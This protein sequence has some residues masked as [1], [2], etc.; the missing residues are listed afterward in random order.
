MAENINGAVVEYFD[1]VD[2]TNTVAARRIAEGC[3]EWHTVIAKSQTAGSG[4]LLRSFFSP[5][6]TGLYMSCV[7]YPNAEDIG[8]ITGMAAVA[9]SEAME[10]L[11]KSPRIKWV[12]D[13]FIDGRKVCGILAKGICREKGMA[14]ILGIGVNVFA[15][16]GGFPEDIRETA[17]YLFDTYDSEKYNNLTSLILSSLQK[18]YADIANGDSPEQYRK[19]CITTGREVKVIPSGNEGGA[20]VA[21]AVDVDDRFRLIIELPDGETR[22]LDSGAVTARI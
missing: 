15:P 22:I 13:I 2:S 6:G 12:N 3:P 4:R 19:R 1:C 14:V 5:D 20:Y 16:K 18:R 17:G 7:L 8:L 10:A 21:R 9:V 11:G